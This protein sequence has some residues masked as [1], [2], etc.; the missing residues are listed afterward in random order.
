MS[1]KHTKCLCLGSKIQSNFAFFF[2][3]LYFPICLPKTYLGCLT[4]KSYIKIKYWL[5][6]GILLL[7]WEYCLE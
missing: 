3:E 1:Q 4:R 2:F 6:M 7:I 5:F